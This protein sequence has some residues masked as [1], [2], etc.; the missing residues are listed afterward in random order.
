MANPSAPGAAQP[1][2][3]AVS[4]CYFFDKL[5]PETRCLIYEYVFGP[6]KYVQRLFQDDEM[7]MLNHSGD[8]L[9][10]DYHDDENND[11][12]N[13]DSEDEEEE[14]PYKQYNVL[15]T[16]ILE[17]NKTAFAEGLDTFY[18]VKIV[19]ASFAEFNRLMRLKK[20]SDLVRNV[21]I[22]ERGYGGM[23]GSPMALE[24]VQDAQF[25][26]RL[27]SCTILLDRL[28]PFG[29]DPVTARRYAR[30]CRLGEVVCTGIGT[31][32]FTGRYSKVQAVYSH[33]AKL[34]PNVA[35]TP[36]GFDALENVRTIL[37]AWN[38][39]PRSP[40]VWG[41]EAQLVPWASHT[42]L[43]L[44]I[45]LVQ[46]CLDLTTPT[47]N[48]SHPRCS[49][50]EDKQ[51][52]SFTASL[53][54]NLRDKVFNG[55][56]K[57]LSRLGPGDNPQ[58]M[59]DFTEWLAV[60][61]RNY[62]VWHDP[63]EADRE[64][65]QWVELG[66]SSKGAEISKS[67]RAFEALHIYDPVFEDNTK[68]CLSM[69]REQ[70]QSYPK[71]RGLVGQDFIW[72]ASK[73]P[74]QQVY[75]LCMAVE[76]LKFPHGTRSLD[77]I[78]LHDWS[79]GLL[80]KYLESAGVSQNSDLHKS[81]LSFLRAHFDYAMAISSQRKQYLQKLREHGSS[82]QAVQQPL[83]EDTSVQYNATQGAT[84]QNE[85]EAGDDPM[86]VDEAEEDKFEGLIYEPFARELGQL[87]REAQ[88]L[89]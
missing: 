50:K 36:T 67:Q 6:E 11:D 15:H 44:F 87:I 13:S 30:L 3:S 37:K 76:W 35:R 82:G 32:T 46:R 41:H 33:I 21:E 64:K 69:A 83:V 54:P 74:L 71:I 19:R 45:G 68:I 75:F 26:P 2:A 62:W 39:L 5:S 89:G 48:G 49:R 20:H 73:A 22:V 8:L 81:N 78:E 56:V 72:E 7:E 17:V 31:Y 16:D 55:L 42:S 4:P 23:H 1:E 38:I 84:G 86:N 18:K 53:E 34:W 85:H 14:E 80:R 24:T 66:E 52:T 12:K 61:M 9:F 77:G 88:A 63:D 43:R 51:L 10:A 65:P 29:N 40:Y 47:S 28:S 58:L 25:L 70:M 27:M 57:P 60:N 79:L 59:E